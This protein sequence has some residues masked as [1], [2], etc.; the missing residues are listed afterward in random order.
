[1]YGARKKTNGTKEHNCMT[2]LNKNMVVSYDEYMK[3]TSGT[4]TNSTADSASIPTVQTNGTP[5]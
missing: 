3:D 1:M 2:I 4:A 5:R